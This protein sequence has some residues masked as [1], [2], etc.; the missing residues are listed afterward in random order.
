VAET[1]AGELLLTLNCHERTE[2][3]DLLGRLRPREAGG[4]EWKDGVVVEAMKNGRPLLVD[5][6]CFHL[7]AQ[8]FH[9]L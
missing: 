1:L 2:T 5:E 6:V 9:L 7:Y 8:L 3:A 4:F